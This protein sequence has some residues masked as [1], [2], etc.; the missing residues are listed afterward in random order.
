LYVDGSHHNYDDVLNALGGV[1]CVYAQNYCPAFFK[2]GFCNTIIIM[3]FVGSS[4][5]TAE[6]IRQV[7]SI[8]KIYCTR[9]PI[10]VVSALYGVTDLLLKVSFGAAGAAIVNAEL[11]LNK[12][13]V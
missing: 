10:L 8:T 1:V 5:G 2:R 11:L 9:E 3:K 12:G 7:A 13:L 4:V 6:A